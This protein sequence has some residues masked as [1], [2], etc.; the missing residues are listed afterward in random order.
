M[1]ARE[2]ARVAFY[3]LLGALML[4][5]LFLQAF[6]GVHRISSTAQLHDDDVEI[7]AARRLPRSVGFEDAIY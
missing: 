5:H 1:L 4:V 6:W 2:L 7:S 3:G